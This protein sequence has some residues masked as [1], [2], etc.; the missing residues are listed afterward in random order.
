MDDLLDIL[1]FGLFM[2]AGVLALY[3]TYV[4]RPGIQ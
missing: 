2:L 1:P 3:F 4:V